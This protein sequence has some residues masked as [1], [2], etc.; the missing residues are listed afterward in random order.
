MLM[1]NSKV[2]LMLLLDVYGKLRNRRCDRRRV[3]LFYRLKIYWQNCESCRTSDEWIDQLRGFLN[4]FR[5]SASLY[6]L[7]RAASDTFWFLYNEFG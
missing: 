3:F 2:R 7:H 6:V 1:I 5:A 4:D